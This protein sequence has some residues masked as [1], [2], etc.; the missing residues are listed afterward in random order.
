[1]AQELVFGLQT[2]DEL[3]E[4]GAIMARAY[5]NYDYVTLYF[6]DMEKSRTGDRSQ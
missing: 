1:M 3:D 5:E 4:A 6:P 2:R